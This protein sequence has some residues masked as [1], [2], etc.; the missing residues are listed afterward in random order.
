MAHKLQVSSAG[1]PLNQNLFLAIFLDNVISGKKTPNRNRD[2]ERNMDWKAAICF[3]T[4][5]YKTTQP[6][7][8]SGSWLAQNCVVCQFGSSTIG[9]SKDSKDVVVNMMCS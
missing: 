9:E 8:R 5:N 2:W 4:Q 6:A 1:I 3:H 7:S